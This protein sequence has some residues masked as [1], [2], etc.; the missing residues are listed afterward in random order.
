MNTPQLPH[1]LDLWQQTI[2][3]QPTES[4]L[5]QFQQLYELILAGNQQ[6]NLT[7]ITD[8]QD[9]WEKHLWDSIRGVVGV[10]AEHSIPIPSATIPDPSANASP[11]QSPITPSKSSTLHSTPHTLHPTPPKIIDIGTGAGFPGLPV[12]IVYPESWMTLVDSTRKKIAFVDSAVKALGLK[13]TRTIA[14]RA[15][16]LATQPA[17]RGNYDVVLVRAVAAAD[18]CLRYALPLLRPGGVAI[19]YRGQWQPSDTEA[20]QPVVAELGAHLATPDR[21]TTPLTNSQRCCLYL[22]KL[23]M[24]SEEKMIVKE[25]M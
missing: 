20:L 13:N 18:L 25:K 7:R 11:L 22:H 15:E 3:W 19:L 9:F 8:P 5:Q 10:G 21:F 16:H 6:L 17:H 2:G 12:A 1:L 14:D 24:E 23:R 4:Q